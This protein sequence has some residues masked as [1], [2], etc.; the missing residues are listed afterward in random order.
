[1]YKNWSTKF[2]VAACLYFAVAAPVWIVWK[3]A[4]YL[5]LSALG[6]AVAFIVYTMAVS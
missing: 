1:M 3:A 4:P 6:A 5:L 2:T